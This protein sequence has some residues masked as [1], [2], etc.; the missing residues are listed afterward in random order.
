M[1]L[2]RCLFLALM[3]LSSVAMSAV[4]KAQTIYLYGFAASF[5][6]STV[7]FTDIYELD[8]AYV[9]TKTRFLYSR[10]D[11]SYQLQQYLADKGYKNATCVTG[12]A[13]TRKDAEKKFTALRKR[14]ITGNHYNV[15]Y[16]KADEFSYQAVKFDGQE[17]EE[18]AVKP[19]KQKRIKGKGPGGP[20][21]RPEAGPG[22]ETGGK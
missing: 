21:G 7:Y 5:N 15:N 1:T 11:Y 17:T 6:D 2:K 14:Y 19:K 18:P 10:N 22:G 12:F 3:V 13:F 4:N 20:D 8:S 16:I 9:D